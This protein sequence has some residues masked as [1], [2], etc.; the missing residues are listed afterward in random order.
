[1][2]LPYLEITAPDGTEQ[3]IP[4]EKIRYTLGRLPDI[5][6]ICI[7]DEL[8]SRVEHC[9]LE[10]HTEGWCVSDAGSSNG[11]VLIRE[12]FQ[13]QRLSLAIQQQPEKRA[14]LKP[15]DLI[16]LAESDWKILFQDQDPTPKRLG[17]GLDQPGVHFVYNLSRQT[18]LCKGNS[19]QPEEITL[20]PK[21]RE[22]VAYL[23]QRNWENDRLPIVCTY[24]ELIEALWPGTD[25]MVAN[26][27][28]GLAREIRKQFNTYGGNGAML[29]ET[30]KGLGYILNIT[31]ER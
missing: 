8:V 1:M 12:G 24:N 29:L 4:L 6:D 31:V 15:G 25:R 13:N 3:V 30:R 17:A 19:P 10:R 5:N 22:L 27:V 11:T 7:A 20:R 26:D 14:P 18:L 21:A 9:V 16:I 23:A 28:Q 2:L